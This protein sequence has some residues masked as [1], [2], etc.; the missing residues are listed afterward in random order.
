MDLITKTNATAEKESTDDE[1]GE[2]LGGGVEDGADD[3]EDAGDQ[4]GE[5]PSQL[6]C[7]V[8]SEE[9]GSQTS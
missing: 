4:H 8:G 6:P 5:P 3:E 7:S 9:C 2:V 1:H